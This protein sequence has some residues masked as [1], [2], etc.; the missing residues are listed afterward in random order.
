MRIRTEEFYT[1]KHIVIYKYAPSRS[2]LQ[3]QQQHSLIKYLFVAFF[4]QRYIVLILFR[5]LVV[6]RRHAT[7]KTKRRM[8]VNAAFISCVCVCVYARDEAMHLT[9]IK[10]KFI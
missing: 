8:C 10:Y 9:H 6:Q 3:Q 1:H 2:S 7:N 5:F 4:S